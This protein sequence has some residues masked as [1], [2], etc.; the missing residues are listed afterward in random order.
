MELDEKTMDVS[1]CTIFSAYLSLDVKISLWITKN[2]DVLAA[3]KPT[4][5]GLILWGP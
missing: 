1:L 4:S 3:V 5:V 2:S